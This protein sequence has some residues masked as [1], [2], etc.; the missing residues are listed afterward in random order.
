MSFPDQS[1]NVVFGRGIVHHLDL[2][3]C[4]SEVSRVLRN[5]GMATF[6]EPLGHNPFLNLYRRWTPDI[7]TADEHP[8]LVSDF[9][10]A[11]RYFSRVNIT[12]YG[13]FSVVS[14]LLDRTAGGA[15]YRIG[16]ALDDRILRLPFIGRY[17]WY[18]LMVCHK[19]A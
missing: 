17:A 18:A 4:F 5:G 9:A 3:R 8:L 1:F 16:K 12:F 11:R 10:L 2:A 6:V 15:A 7:R 19:A 13:L 14:V